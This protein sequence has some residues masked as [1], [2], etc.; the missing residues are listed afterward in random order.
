MKKILLLSFKVLVAVLTACQPVGQS[1]GPQMLKP[2][3]EIDGMILAT[4][5]ADAPPLGAFC[6][7]PQH[8]GNTTTSHCDVP[9]LSKLAIGHV[10]M[11]A[12]EAL[13]DLDWSQ[14]TWEL[15]I[16]DRTLDLE[17]FGTYDFVLPTMSHRP[18][19]IR[20]VFTQ[21]TAWDVV[22][23]NLKP[24]AFTLNGLARSETDTYTWIVDFIIE[25]PYMFDSGSM[26]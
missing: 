25:A 14:W 23:T 9:L 24:G 20:E 2:G 22:L 18:S 5:A 1:T 13:T 4:G 10:F 21:F 6:S 16:D 26:P 19:S 7:L 17:R 3:D 15:S 11:L 8:S 12:D